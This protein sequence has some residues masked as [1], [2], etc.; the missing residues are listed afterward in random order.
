[1]SNFNIN[2]PNL[3]HLNLPPHK[4]M[5][6]R[7][8]WIL[9]VMTPLK[10]KHTEFIEFYEDQKYRVAH[11]SQ[12]I[13]IEKVLND[14]FDNDDRGIYIGLRNPID[15]IFLRQKSEELPIIL[16]NKWKSLTTYSI[17]DFSTH[18]SYVWIATAVSTGESPFD[19]SAYWSIHAD[20]FYLHQSSEYLPKG[21]IVYVPIAVVF[22]ED[23]MR[24]LI[25]LYRLAG[26]Y[27]EIQTY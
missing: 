9:L 22:D 8:K 3:V 2:W 11:T 15:Q 12:K 18:G 19:G 24:A 21:F 27:Y 25:D 20:R 26:M 17:G 13:S 10:F 14:K 23:Q 6:I 7:W 5:I 1:M 16:Y 4:R